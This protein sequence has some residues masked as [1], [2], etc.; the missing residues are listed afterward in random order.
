MAS[1]VFI[2][3]SHRDNLAP[4]GSENGFVSRLRSAVEVMAGM[5]YG[6]DISFF[7]DEDLASGCLWEQAIYDELANCRVLLP[8]VSP[9]WQNSKW[10]GKE[11]DAVWER[12]R[13][14]HGD[15]KSVV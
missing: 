7:F 10:A 13:E 6:C 14:D 9:S 2:S 3:Y 5:K 15:R 12:V 1:D 8:I 11:W 4:N